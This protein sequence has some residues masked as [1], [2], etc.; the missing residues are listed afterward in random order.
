MKVHPFTVRLSRRE[1]LKVIVPQINVDY[2]ILPKVIAKRILNH[3]CR[4][5][6][7]PIKQDSLKEDT[8]DKM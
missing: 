3:Y 2:K 7:I 5:S 4:N 8:L 6:F 1:V